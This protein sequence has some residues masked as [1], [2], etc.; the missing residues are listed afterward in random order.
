[1]KFILEDD[2]RIAGMVE[3]NI[4]TNGNHYKDF[5]I[6][7][8][9]NLD[10]KE[11]SYTINSVEPYPI[12]REIFYAK[13]IGYY[14]FPEI[15]GLTVHAWKDKDFW[16]LIPNLDKRRHEFTNLSS[17]KIDINYIKNNIRNLVTHNP[18]NQEAINVII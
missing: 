5:K 11:V 4:N 14:H 12:I 6:L 13:A 10:K 3:D 1:M 2:N 15:K 18:D 8:I 17:E 7:L 9:P 16:K